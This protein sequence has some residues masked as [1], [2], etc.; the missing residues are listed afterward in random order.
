[1]MQ[2]KVKTTR[3]PRLRLDKNRRLTPM[4]I[5]C[6]A[7]VA[8]LAVL[9][10]ALLA[11]RGTLLH[12][13]F[14]YDVTDTG[15]DFFHSIEYVRGRMPY[16][17]F[18][19]LYPPLANLFFYV[20]YLLVPK[21]Q[22]ATWTESYISSLNMRGTERDLRLQQAT[23]MLFVVFVIVVVLGIVS[24]TERLTRSC[25]GGKS[26]W[27]S[28]QCSAMGYCTAWNAAIFCCCAGR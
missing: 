14:F 3:A 9:L 11:S 19:T 16:G 25:G 5:Y 23:M 4:Q 8:C 12:R 24:M 21:T 18:D 17:Q 10:L 13:F 20:L 22:S 2:Q 6:W 27:H 28:V 26:C 1:M 15:M 7:T